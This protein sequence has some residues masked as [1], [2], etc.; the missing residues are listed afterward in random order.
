MY[1]NSEEE[2]IGVKDGT[3]CYSCCLERRQG[4]IDKQSDE[5]RGKKE[6]RKEKKRKKRERAEK[7]EEVKEQAEGTMRTATLRRA[8]QRFKRGS[9]V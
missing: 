2:S 8:G 7:R 3:S 4:R 9:G 1:D 6:G 5:G